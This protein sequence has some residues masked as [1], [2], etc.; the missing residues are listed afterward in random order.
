MADIQMPSP[1]P[2]EIL[3]RVHASSVTMGDVMLRKLP[4]A[5]LTVVGV[6]VGFKPKDIAGVEFAGEVVE[7]GPQ[8]TRFAQGD[9]VFGTTTGLTTGGNAEYLCIPERWKAGVVSKIPA[10]LSYEDAAVL[11]VGSMTATQLL[12]KAGVTSGDRV[13]I[14]GASGSVGTY[15]VQLA[16]QIG[17]TVTGVCS[18]ANLELVRSL[19]AASVVDYAREDF[20]K[21]AMMFDVVFD[22]VGK[23]SRSRAKPVMASG[24]RYVSVKYPTKEVLEQLERNALL[25]SKGS[26]KPVVDRRY[27]LDQIVEAHRYVE[28][29]RKKGNVVVAIGPASM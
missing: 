6:L 23:I 9:R 13:L 14:Y 20:A 2:G 5:L 11:P 28:S 1:G 15:A 24:A 22:A 16:L 29:R 19:G 10:G 21:T 7:A 27:S 12:D 8:V 26:I 4:R 25:A 18:T 3:I 17:A